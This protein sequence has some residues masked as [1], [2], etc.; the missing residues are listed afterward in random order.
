MTQTVVIHAS[1]TPM[2]RAQR[3]CRL[4]GVPTVGAHIEAMAEALAHWQ[5]WDREASGAAVA[6]RQSSESPTPAST[7]ESEAG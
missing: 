2:H 1:D 4:I 5:R 3:L 6:P 7:A